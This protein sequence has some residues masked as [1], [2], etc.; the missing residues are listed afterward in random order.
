MSVIS[1]LQPLQLFPISQYL[2]NKIAR[3][4]TEH[5]QHRSALGIEQWHLIGH[6]A[7][8]ARVS[9]NVLHSNTTHVHI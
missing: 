3:H 8:H 7:G 9:Q 1:C 6:W 4:S 5:V 2:R